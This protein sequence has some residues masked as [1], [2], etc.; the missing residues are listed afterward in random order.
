M[1]KYKKNSEFILRSSK[2]KSPKTIRLRLITFYEAIDLKYGDWVY[3]L[4]N[5]GKAASI[6]VASKL[7]RYKNDPLRIEISFKFGLY[8]KW[9]A[10]TEDILNN[11]YVEV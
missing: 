3:T 5:K 2:L 1:K 7:K 8:Q 11:I 4:D 10:N 6:R 9:R